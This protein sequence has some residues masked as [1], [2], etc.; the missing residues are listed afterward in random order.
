MEEQNGWKQKYVEL[1]WAGKYNKLDKGAES[2]VE[3]P[4]LPFQV[5]ET[6][7]K[8]RAQEAFE[9]SLFPE[10]DYPENYPRKAS[11]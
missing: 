4:N 3:K 1:I 2:I 5:V 10:N 7:N 8:P 6:V 11:L 9:S